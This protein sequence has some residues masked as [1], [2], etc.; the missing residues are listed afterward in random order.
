MS[1]PISDDINL[2]NGS[3]PRNELPLLEEVR[4]INKFEEPLGRLAEGFFIKGEYL[5]WRVFQGAEKKTAHDVS[6]AAKCMQIE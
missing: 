5:L 2:L 4:W 1:S 3:V 6:H